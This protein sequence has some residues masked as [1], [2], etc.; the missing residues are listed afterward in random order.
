MVSIELSDASGVYFFGFKLVCTEEEEKTIAK[1]RC[2][3]TDRDY[4]QNYKVTSKAAR[5]PYS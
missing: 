2:A 4:L 1:A 3:T 5:V